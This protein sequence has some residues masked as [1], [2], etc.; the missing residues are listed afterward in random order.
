MVKA[1][2]VVTFNHFETAVKAATDLRSKPSRPGY[3]TGRQL[4]HCTSENL[5]EREK[6]SGS[7]ERLLL[8]GIV[9]QRDGDLRAYVTFRSQAYLGAPLCVFL[10]LTPLKP[11]QAW[12]SNWLPSSQ[13]E[14]KNRTELNFGNIKILIWLY[15]PLPGSHG[16]LH[17]GQILGF[18]NTRLPSLGCASEC[19]QSCSSF[20]PTQ[21]PRSTQQRVPSMCPSVACCFEWMMKFLHLATMTPSP[22]VGRNGIRGRG[23]SPR[24][25]S[26]GEPSPI[27]FYHKHD[28]H[29]GFTNFSDHPVCY[30]GAMYPTSEHLFQSFKVNVLRNIYS[31]YWSCSSF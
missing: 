25:L 4:V 5:G 18:Q 8:P 20:Y 17:L 9:G 31:L 14:V 16:E 19:S 22:Q 28:P 26:P 12:G 10:I 13:K 21:H 1:E 7:K 11:L 6:V 27:F 23:R 2:V 30:E 29:Y 24:Y 3:L 15:S